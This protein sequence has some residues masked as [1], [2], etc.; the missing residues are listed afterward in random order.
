MTAD[1][2]LPGV[3]NIRRWDYKVHN[4]ST[5]GN[6]YVYYFDSGDGF[7]GIYITKFIKF[8]SVNMCCL[9]YVSYISI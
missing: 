2:W 3:G 7:A 5:G 6:G 9:L 4:E 1:Q 8:Y